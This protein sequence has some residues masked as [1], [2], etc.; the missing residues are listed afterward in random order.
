MWRW[1]A[2]SPCIR[3]C[4]S[5]TCRRRSAGSARPGM[6]PLAPA[7]GALLYFA[8]G[9]NRVRRR[10]LRLMGADA[11]PAYEGPQVAPDDP[12]ADLETAI[13]AVTRRRATPGRVVAHL[14]CGDAAY[15]EMLAAIAGA[16]V[17]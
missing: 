9:I 12:L 10:A 14:F 17:S 6:A 1:R 8:F 13:G 15:P 4:A 7:F 3:S 2:W 11:L 5:A 16:K